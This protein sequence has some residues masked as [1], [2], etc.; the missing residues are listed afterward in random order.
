[1]RTISL[2]VSLGKENNLMPDLAGQSEAN[3]MSQL[4]AMNLGL[5]V[6]REEESSDTVPA[7][8]VTRTDP[9]AETELQEGQSVTVYVSLG[10]GKMPELKNQSKENAKSILDAMNLNLRITYLEEESDDIAS[11]NVTRTVPASDSQLSRGQQVTVYVSKG[12]GKVTV[13]PV[14]GLSV[15]DAI[16]L[17]TENDLKYEIKRV[18]SDTDEKDRVVRQSE[19]SHYN[20][21]NVL[22][23]HALLGAYSPAGEEWADEMCRVIDANHEYACNF[24]RDN[25]KGV[26]VMRPE[27]T[28][29]LYLDCADWCRKHGVTI[30]ELQERGIRAGVIWQDGEAFMLKDTI[31]M[32]LALPHSLLEEAMQRLKEKACV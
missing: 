20:D 2:K 10:S 3:A 19:V 24:I 11:G 27:G 8:S 14:T 5:N 12:S 7:G 15:R 16:D 31:R 21:C 18:Y 6:R 22:S 26:R 4:K 28:Y 13:P 30:R 29:M 23:L 32:N 25:F 17:L 1:M 9:A